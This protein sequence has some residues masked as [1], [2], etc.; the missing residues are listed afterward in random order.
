MKVSWTA[1]PRAHSK[2]AGKMSFSARRK[3]RGL[4]M[5]HVNP[6]DG[7]SSPQRVS[8]AVQRVSHNS[9]DAPHASLPE[10][11]DQIFRCS[12]AHR[13]FFPITRTSPA[14]GLHGTGVPQ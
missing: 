1:A 2:A 5:P 12:S 9:I 3:S 6:V 7:F 8:K 11:F 10:S 4:L 14:E 13:L